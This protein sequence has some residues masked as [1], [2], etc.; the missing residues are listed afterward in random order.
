MSHT[1]KTHS[2]ATHAAQQRHK[3]AIASAA[4]LARKKFIKAIKTKQR[5]LGL[6][7]AT[8]RAMLLA[9]TGKTS[10]TDC[11]LTELGLVAGYLSSV[12]AVSP[13][14]TRVGKPVAAVAPDRQALRHK[15]NALVSE[16]V[17]LTGIRDPVA[18]VNA[19]LSKN[20][21]CSTLE[22]ADAH[23]LY[24]L[25]GTLSHNLTCKRRAAAAAAHKAAA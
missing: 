12:G 2:A 1:V 5:Q 24:K 22:F 15:V 11:T 20:G 3:D 7:D 23:I 18:Y 9:R 13:K 14:A 21:W 8:Y 4:A 6:D 16:L 17:Q 19:I 25:V 10:T